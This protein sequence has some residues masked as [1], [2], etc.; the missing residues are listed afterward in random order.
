[1][2]NSLGFQI[3]RKILRRL[4]RIVDTDRNGNLSFE[5]FTSLIL[6]VNDAL[7]EGASTQDEVYEVD[8]S[9][10]SNDEIEHLETIFEIVG[11]TSSSIC[12]PPYPSSSDRC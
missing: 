2:F 6:L 12:F 5:E 8:M 3:S 1:M 9:Q 11:A 7:R 4:I 10:F